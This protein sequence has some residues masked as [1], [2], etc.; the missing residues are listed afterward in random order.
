MYEDPDPGSGPIRFQTARLAPVA[1]VAQATG[2][3][4][5]LIGRQVAAG[6]LRRLNPGDRP[7]WAIAFAGGRHDGEAF[8]AG[9]RNEI[10]DIPVVGGAAV[11]TLSHGGLGYSGL[12]CVVALIPAS[13]GDPQILFESM[14]DVDERTAGECLGARIAD[15][16]GE[17]ETALLFFDSMRSATPPQLHAGSYLLD[18]LYKGIGGDTV[19]F[20]GGGTLCDFG[21]SDSFVFDGRRLCRHGIVAVLLPRAIRVRTRIL[22][23]CL[24]ASSFMTITGID[25]AVVHE[26]DNLPATKALERLAGGPI[27]ADRA[28]D[29]ALRVLLG[30]Q[31]GDLFGP[32]DGS[33]YVNRLIVSIDPEAGTLTLFEPDFEVGSRVQVLTR[34][35]RLMFDA[36][37]QGAEALIK[38][39]AGSHSLLGLYI[40]CAGRAGMLCGSE[41]EEARVVIETLGDTLPIAGFFSG[42]EIA[43]LLGRSRP[44]DLT[45]VLIA[46]C[47][48]DPS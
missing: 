43:P 25:G 42:V 33:S 1:G 24:P 15:I 41:D 3:D 14:A 6:A 34:D 20:V 10:G 26:I 27:D 12:E 18:G 47:L 48:E 19:D 46:L 32:S 31:H 17:G 11:G 45:G 40:D 7:G 28:R 21:F 29:L 38:D 30:Q 2:P 9:M 36:A 8:L 37:R 22:R 13:A 39:I 44:L 4:S 16:A 35:N 23:A 5:R